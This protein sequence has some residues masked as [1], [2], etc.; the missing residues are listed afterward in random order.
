MKLRMA[1]PRTAD[2]FHGASRN[3][4]GD[5]KTCWMVCNSTLKRSFPGSQDSTAGFVRPGKGEKSEDG[6][7][8][9]SWFGELCYRCCLARVPCLRLVPWQHGLLV[10]MFLWSYATPRI[11]SVLV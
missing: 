2:P 5:A 7:F 8:C 4:E 3:T 1:E 11:V 9:F 10:S 6:R